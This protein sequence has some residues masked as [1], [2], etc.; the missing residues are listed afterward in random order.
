MKI[1]SAIIIHRS[2]CQSKRHYNQAP[3]SPRTILADT[4]LV[5]NL[6]SEEYRKIILN[7]CNTLEERFSLIDANQVREQLQQA[8]KYV[9]RI[10][11]EM[12]TVIQQDNLPKKIAVLFDQTCNAH[13][14]CHL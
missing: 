4:P 6:Q 9:E 1:S 12:K 5:S 7:G 13:A 11:P 2:P 3:I 10:S 8:H 14:N